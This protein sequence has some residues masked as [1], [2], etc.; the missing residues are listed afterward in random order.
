ML[1][2]SM[3]SIAMSAMDAF[4]TLRLLEL[5]MIEANP[6]MLAAIEAGL[7][8]FILT[9]MTLTGIGVFI[10]V[11][12]AKAKMLKFLRVGY[13]LTVIFLMYASLISWELYNLSILS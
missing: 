2:L 11:Y 13:L 3:G 12:L 9:K 7:T 4:F 6:V 8:V 5:G 1:L 10:L